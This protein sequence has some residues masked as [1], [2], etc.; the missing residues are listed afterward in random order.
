MVVF[1]VCLRFLVFIC[2]L[3]DELQYPLALTFNF[4]LTLGYIW[5]NIIFE[6]KKYDDGYNVYN[7]F[8]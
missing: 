5:Q 2:L 3:N 4:L 8:Y 7:L 1:T 6:V